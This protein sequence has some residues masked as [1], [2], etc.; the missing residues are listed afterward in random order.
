[1][2]LRKNHDDITGDLD[3]MKLGHGDKKTSAETSTPYYTVAVSNLDSSNGRPFKEP[4]S[5]SKP[6]NGADTGAKRFVLHRK[7][8][9]GVF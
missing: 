3:W 7:C 8:F 9:N 4:V 6:K 2:H 5:N 1:M